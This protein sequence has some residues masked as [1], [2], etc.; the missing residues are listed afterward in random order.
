MIVSDLLKRMLAAYPGF[1]AKAGETWAPVFR[2]R[3]SRHEGNALETAA[4]EVLGSFKPTTRQPF[5]IPADFEAHLP[6]GKLDLPAETPKLDFAARDQ[7]L[8]QIM[9][10]W[11]NR[12]GL[13]SSKGVA[14]VMRALEEMAKPLATTMAWKP[15]DHRLILDADQ[16]RIAKQRAVSYRRL[17]EFG[18]IPKSADAWWDQIDT[19]QRRWGIE[20]TR[21][22]WTTDTPSAKEAA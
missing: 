20:L 15:G 9:G 4:I 1:D 18:Q 3:L 14:E 5:P 21:S 6:S 16:L 13:K 19:I 11:R 17:I 22:D 7:K 2:A 10:D 8:A 12:Q